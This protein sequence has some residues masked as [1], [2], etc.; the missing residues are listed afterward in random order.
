[1]NLKGGPKLSLDKLLQTSLKSSFTQGVEGRQVSSK[2]GTE[3]SPSE[4]SGGFYTEEHFPKFML[5][6]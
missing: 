4:L 1:M 6:P 2:D 5:K 3:W